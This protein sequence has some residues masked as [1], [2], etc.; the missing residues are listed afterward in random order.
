MSATLAGRR[1]FLRVAARGV[2]AGSWPA[3]LPRMSFA[4]PQT[5]PRGDVLVC[6]FAGAAD[7]LNVVP[8]GERSDMLRPTLA[9]P[10]PDDLKAK[11]TGRAVDLDGVLRVAPGDGVGTL[12]WRRGNWRSCM[13][14]EH[15]MRAGRIS[16]RWN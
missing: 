3:W 5:A 8:H 2:V 6:L 7:M 9:I 4:P 15:R 1:D 10:R 16:R 13:R 14:A 11:G 12:A